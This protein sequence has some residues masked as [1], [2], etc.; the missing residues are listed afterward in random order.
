MNVKTMATWKAVKMCKT[1]SDLL[2]GGANNW[3]GKNPP[4]GS[5]LL[6]SH[7]ANTAARG[8]QPSTSARPTPAT[9][10]HE[11][12][13]A[14]QS[15]EA[16][17]GAE[18]RVTSSPLESSTSLVASTLKPSAEEEFQSTLAALKI[19]PVEGLTSSTI[20]PN[21]QK[22]IETFFKNESNMEGLSPQ[23]VES[24][25]KGNGSNEPNLQLK[26]EPLESGHHQEHRPIEL[27]KEPQL[28]QKL[29]PQLFQKQKPQFFQKQEPQFFQKQE[30]QLFQK[31]E[32]QFFQKQEPPPFLKQGPQL[33]QKPE[34]QL[35]QKQD[36]QLFKKQEPQF[37]QK[38]DPQLFQKQEP[39]VFQKQE[40][41]PFLKQE[42]R[43]LKKQESNPFKAQKPILQQEPH[44]LEENLREHAGLAEGQRTRALSQ[45]RAVIGLEDITAAQE[46]NTKGNKAS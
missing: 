20:T 7:L 37:F 39:K 27:Q 30:P 19:I 17:P 42:P 46:R 21:Q 4:I 36:P 41:P 16:N 32:P 23:Q 28:V 31:Q 8:H 3:S 2:S 1:N 9:E 43:L 24:Q 22:Q 40:P 15:L 13:K 35:F 25:A 12:V 45:K 10:G 11:A 5:S 38:Q 33:F 14:Y 44:Q 6:I 34:P 29:E 26:K 18:L